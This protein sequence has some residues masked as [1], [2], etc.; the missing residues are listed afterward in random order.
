MEYVLG[1]SKSEV[2]PR[3][4][5]WKIGPLNNARWLTLAI[6][7]MCLWT[8]GAYPPELQDKLRNAVKYIVQ[9]YAV[10]CLEIKTDSKFHNHDPEDET[11]G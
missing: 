10:S 11:A 2:N 1:I 4:A 6:R 5:A 8:R 3:F 7:L 9:V